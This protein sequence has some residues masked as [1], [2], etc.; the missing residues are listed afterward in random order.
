[1]Q[2]SAVD[3][4][5]ER[6]TIV[7]VVGQYV[8]LSKAGKN[9]RGLSPFNS[10]KTPSFYVSPDR[11]VYYCFSSGKG[12]DIF[13]FVQEMEGV[14]FRGAL[15]ILA[16]RAGIE[17]VREN[18]EARDQRERLF[19]LLEAATVWFEEQLAHRS[20]ALSY[21]QERGLQTDGIKKWR[22]GYAPSGWSNLLEAMKAKG[23]KDDEL[24][25]AGLTKQN[26]RG[27]W[28]D[29]FRGRIMF[30]IF[31]TAGRPVAFS[32]RIF[33]E[34]EGKE[35]AKYLNSP[36]T[37]LYDKSSIL[38][39]Y[40]RAKQSM[41]K[42]DFAILVEGQMDILM[43]H[44]AGFT[45]TVA[46]SG[47]GLTPHHLELI[48]RVTKNVI[49]AFDADQA[50]FRSAGR[51]ATMALSRSMDV[52]VVALPDGVDPADMVKDDPDKWREAI[53]SST[54]I[55]DFYLSVLR[56][57]I[58]D[59]RKFAKAVRVYVLPFV[60]QI[61]QAIDREQFIARVAK[62][63]KVPE[64][65]VRE[66]LA[67]LKRDEEPRAPT[68]QKE[69]VVDR[70]ASVMSRYASLTRTLQGVLWYL[71]E[72]KSTEEYGTFTKSLSPHMLQELA[73]VA[74]N[75]KAEKEPLLFEIER[76]IEESE[77][78]DEL[79]ATIRDEFIAEAQKN[80]IQQLRIA[81]QEAE[82]EGDTQKASQL[83]EQLRDLLTLVHNG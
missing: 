39:G 74:E 62:Y 59:E 22:V 6:L 73:Q 28:Y 63:L 58:D 45:N 8:K 12:G 56:S 1:M 51:G 61:P 20:E 82:L 9:F 5:K 67:G 80:E 13:T 19:L 65:A 29:R 35:N 49:M 64:E 21:L 32:G 43:S 34:E 30:P 75:L 37:A 53:R 72:T 31:D 25:R 48:E 10:E 11:G 23:Y 60:A 42:Y 47:T 4:V 24:E 66:E 70:T 3:Q 44:Q 16:D 81:Y 69:R 77:G 2:D 83:Q 15:K 52:K 33:D 76:S 17:L 14:D 38:Y 57:K 40:D 26:D 79:L 27:G 7:E 36:E 18:K 50:G 71:E 46:V 68:T 54:H 78:E 55:I 41:R